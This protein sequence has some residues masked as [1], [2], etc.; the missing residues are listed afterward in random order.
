MLFPWDISVVDSIGQNI[1]PSTQLL[2]ETSVQVPAADKFD[3]T[4]PCSSKDKGTE[5]VQVV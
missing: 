5:I 1:A 4:A 2:Q 3:G